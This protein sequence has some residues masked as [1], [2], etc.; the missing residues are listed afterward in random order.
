MVGGTGFYV[1][2]LVEASLLADV[3]PDA[4]LR[5]DLEALREREGVAGL[6]ARLERLD[7]TR[8]ATVD[9]ANPRRLI[10]AIEVAERG[11]SAGYS[12]TAPSSTIFGIDVPGDVLAARIERRVH[13]MYAGGLV[14]ETR[15]LL[16]RGIPPGAPALTGVGY[17]E[18]AAVLDGRLS[19]DEAK[20][21]TAT[22]T[23][24]YSRRQ[25]TWFRHQLPVHWRPPET[26]VKTLAA[27]LR[28]LD[29]AG[30]S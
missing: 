19:L 2:A 16:E 17:R 22:R 14:D 15:A 18:A 25:R 23:R 13:A 11:G 4:D 27:Y 5:R 6:A 12:R 9:R 3:P 29:E 26:I 30:Q 1:K 24:Q 7:P 28:D 8:A 10:R 21:R 20:H